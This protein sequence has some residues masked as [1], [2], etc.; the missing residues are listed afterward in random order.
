MDNAF[1]QLGDKAA[2]A[3][4]IGAGLQAMVNAAIK[5]KGAMPARGGASDLSDI[6]VARAELGPQA[7]DARRSAIPA[8]G[9]PVSMPEE[10]WDRVRGEPPTAG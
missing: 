10:V 2:W 5:G 3:P 1:E 4:R 7:A 6:D 8:P 9:D